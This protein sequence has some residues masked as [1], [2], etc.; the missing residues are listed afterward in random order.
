M[1]ETKDGYVQYLYRDVIGGF[2]EFPTEN[3]KAI[4][5][6]ELQPIEAHH[7]SSVLSVM[8]TDFFESQVGEYGE[9]ILSILIA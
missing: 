2:F 5:P 1:S 6:P 7:G 4:L 3:A 8:A 9:L